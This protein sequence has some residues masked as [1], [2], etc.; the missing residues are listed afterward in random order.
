MVQ[1]SMPVQQVKLES[2][3][4]TSKNNTALT[5]VCQPNPDGTETTTGYISLQI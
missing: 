2:R 5:R 3:W 1:S 4:F